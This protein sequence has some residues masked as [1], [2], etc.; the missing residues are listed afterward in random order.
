MEEQSFP[1]RRVSATGG[2]DFQ[3]ASSGCVRGHRCVWLYTQNL[4]TLL[5]KYLIFKIKRRS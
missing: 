1:R 5:Y 3:K 2:E 4:Y